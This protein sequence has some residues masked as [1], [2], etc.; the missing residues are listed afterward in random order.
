MVLEIGSSIS[1]MRMEKNG[2]AVPSPPSQELFSLSMP[3]WHNS[4]DSRISG[5]LREV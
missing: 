3:S 1:S 4:L 5:W 2:C